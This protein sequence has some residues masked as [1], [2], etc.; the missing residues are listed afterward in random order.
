MLCMG[1]MDEI[2][3][4]LPPVDIEKLSPPLQSAMIRDDASKKQDDKTKTV[5]VLEQVSDIVPCRITEKPPTIDG[6][7]YS[8]ETS[9]DTVIVPDKA[10]SNNKHPHEASSGFVAGIDVQRWCRSTPLPVSIDTSHRLRRSSLLE[11]AFR[12][13]SVLILHALQTRLPLHLY[14]LLH[15][16]NGK[17]THLLLLNLLISSIGVSNLQKLFLG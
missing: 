14:S 1:I 9:I 13:S 6:Q 12:L 8:I 10:L 15:L 16:R 11:L 2:L 4:Q 7:A 3:L 5:V 17:G